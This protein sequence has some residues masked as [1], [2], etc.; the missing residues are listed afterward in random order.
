MTM[1]VI[2]KF[3]NDV[4]P[5]KGPRMRVKRTKRTTLTDVEV[6]IDEANRRAM[7]GEWAGS[8]GRTFVGLYAL[9]HRMIYGVV[10]EELTDRLMFNT[11]AKMAAK[12]MH[13]CFDD[14]P[15]ELAA[16]VRW[17]WEVEKRKNSWAQSKA[18]DR[19]RLGPKVQFS[20]GVV[21]DYRIYL[22]QQR[23]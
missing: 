7:S 9:C 13:E 23:R 18:I 14:D 5:P 22:K 10:P 6:A 16:F 19:R 12:V 8:K 17:S 1:S 11:V 21:T 15:N 3:I 2:E 20:R 4:D